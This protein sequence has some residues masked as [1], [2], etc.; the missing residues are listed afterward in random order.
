MAIIFY[1]N[2]DNNFID[3]KSITIDYSI[4]F[5]LEISKKNYLNDNMHDKLNSWVRLKRKI[6]NWGEMQP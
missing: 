2:Y 5:K 3:N 6:I 1:Q 4:I